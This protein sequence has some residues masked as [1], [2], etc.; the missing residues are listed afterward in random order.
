MKKNY[1]RPAVCTILLENTSRLLA[2]SDIFQVN[3]NE[4]AVDPEETW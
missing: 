2:G 4:E 1:I 3:I